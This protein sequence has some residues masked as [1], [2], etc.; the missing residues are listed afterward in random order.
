M[1]TITREAVNLTTIQ[2]IAHT[3][4]LY[5]NRYTA[6]GNRRSLTAFTGAGT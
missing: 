5:R 1:A 6:Y 4:T 2:T 3:V